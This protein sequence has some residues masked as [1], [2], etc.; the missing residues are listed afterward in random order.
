MRAPETDGDSERAAGMV[1]DV[2][3]WETPGKSYTTVLSLSSN[4]D[5]W[6]KKGWKKAKATW[7]KA[8]TPKYAPPG[9]RIPLCSMEASPWG[10]TLMTALLEVNK[11]REGMNKSSGTKINSW[12]L[13]VLVEISLLLY[14]CFIHLVKHPSY[15]MP[16]KKIHFHKGPWQR[17]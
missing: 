4:V 12:Y 6:E 8:R 10:Y 3:Y 11:K 15:V 14:T 1:K 7:S 2:L 16:L 9:Y 13:S 5:C 17:S